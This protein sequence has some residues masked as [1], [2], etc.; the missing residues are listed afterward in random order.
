MKKSGFF[1]AG[2]LAAALLTWFIV[3]CIA[4]MNTRVAVNTEA[5]MQRWPA[6]AEYSRTLYL[7]DGALFFSLLPG[8]AICP[9]KRSLRKQRW[10]CCVLRRTFHV[11]KQ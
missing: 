1:I 4:S 6:L 9:I 8:R 5:A 3:R 2:A 7:K 11:K 10:S